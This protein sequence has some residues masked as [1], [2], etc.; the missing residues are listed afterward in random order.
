MMVSAFEIETT[1]P[2]ELQLHFRLTGGTRRDIGYWRSDPFTSRFWNDDN[3][4]AFRPA[5][6]GG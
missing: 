1:V 3:D 4:R 2:T 5:G 6:G